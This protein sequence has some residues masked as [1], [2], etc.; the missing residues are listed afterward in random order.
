MLKIQ[1]LVANTWC[2]INGIYTQENKIIFDCFL[3]LVF[4]Y[5]YYYYYYV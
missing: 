5:Y 2:T 4:Y 1:S 3:T